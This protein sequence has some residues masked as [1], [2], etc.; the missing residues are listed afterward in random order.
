[1]SEQ[2][3][4]DVLVFDENGEVVTEELPPDRTALPSAP[5]YGP[6]DGDPEDAAPTSLAIAPRSGPGLGLTLGQIERIGNVLYRS[7]YFKDARDANQ[8]IVKVL[9]GQEVG[10]PPFRAVTGFHVIEGKPAMSAGL[11]GSLVAESRR[12]GYRIVECTDK[13]C[14]LEWTDRGEVVGRS[15]FTDADRE[16]AGLSLKTQQGKPSSWAKYPSDMFFARALTQGARRFC[17]D[18]FGGAIYDPEE[19]AS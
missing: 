11:V 18:V 1:M 12:Y 9:A 14:V 3:L 15:S 17:P 2:T 5:V 13:G 4:D 6:G 16:R 10:V 7:G 8:C 19:L